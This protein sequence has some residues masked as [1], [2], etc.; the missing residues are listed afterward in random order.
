M[1]IAPPRSLHSE[2]LCTTDP[3][4]AQIVEIVEEPEPEQELQLWL[5]LLAMAEELEQ[6]QVLLVGM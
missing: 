3:P 4:A 1:P 2:I 6:G 5:L